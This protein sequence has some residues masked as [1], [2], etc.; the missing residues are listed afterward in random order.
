M[1]FPESRFN[2]SRMLKVRRARTRVGSNTPKASSLL[3][4]EQDF[5]KD[6]AQRFFFN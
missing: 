5:M 3:V 6:L 1:G 2:F 4:S